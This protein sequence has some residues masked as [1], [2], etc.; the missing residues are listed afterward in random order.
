MMQTE[1]YQYFENIME[2]NLLIPLIYAIMRSRSHAHR[3]KS[4]HVRMEEVRELPL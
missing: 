3:R 2:C 4:I 1:F